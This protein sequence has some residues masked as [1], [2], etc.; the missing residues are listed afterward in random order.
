MGRYTIQRLLA[1]VPVLVVVAIVTFSLIHITPGDPVAL[2]AG[3][4]A[5]P[6]QKEAIR[7]DMGL[8]KPIYQQLVIYFAD[9]LRGDHR[10]IDIQ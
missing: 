1:M 6:E 3:D 9:I 7:K 4:E 5:T 2:M 10:R 8:D